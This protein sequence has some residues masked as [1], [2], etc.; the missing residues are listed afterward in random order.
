MRSAPSEVAATTGARAATPD[1]GDPPV[2][3]GGA[4]RGLG[5]GRAPLAGASWAASGRRQDVLARPGA[6]AV[7]GLALDPV[8][9][10]LGARS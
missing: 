8:L 4:V 2:A 6:V 10:V 7:A 1:G 5:A 9:G 3:Q